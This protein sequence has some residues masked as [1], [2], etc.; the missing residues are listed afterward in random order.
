MIA[1]AVLT[2]TPVHNNLLELWSL[3][4]WLHP[5]LFTPASERAFKDAFDLTRGAYSLPFLNSAK[6]LLEVMML[7]RTKSSVTLDVPPRE[8]M[9]V[10]VPL[11]DAQRFWTYRLLTRMDGADLAGVFTAS[12]DQ[13]PK[14]E[15]EEGSLTSEPSAAS[16][17]T[18]TTDDGRTQVRELMRQQARVQTA[19]GQQHRK[20]MPFCLI[21]PCSDLLQSGSAS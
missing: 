10:F 2:G 17:S 13:E 9:T 7:R 11:S 15:A 8:E 5:M 18:T 6:A 3:L 19:T 20:R 16:T 1:A 4:H 14:A 12:E 21:L